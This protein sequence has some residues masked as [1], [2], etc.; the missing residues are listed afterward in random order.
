[1]LLG[2]MKTIATIPVGEYPHGLRPSPDGKWVYVANAKGTTLSVIDTATNTKVADIEVGQKPVQVGFSPDGKF[3]YFSLNA[4]N[5]VGKVDVATRAPVGKV[6]VGIGPIQVFVTPDSEYL[7]AANQGTKDNPST[8]VS[9]IDT[10]TFK[11]VG[12]VPGVR[13]ACHYPS[14]ER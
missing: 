12:G 1:M 5:A 10:T 4:E 8:T 2:V 14:L 11:V 6:N 7:L 9:I 13:R 3:V